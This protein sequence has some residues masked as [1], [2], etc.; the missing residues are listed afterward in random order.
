[1]YTLTNSSDIIS[2][3]INDTLLSTDLVNCNALEVNEYYNNTLCL[4]ELDLV[5][6]NNY[7][8]DTLY[9]IGG[10]S[11]KILVQ[12]TVTDNEETYY[13][14]LA[15]YSRGEQGNSLKLFLFTDIKDS[16]IKLN[17]KSF[18]KVS[19]NKIVERLYRSSIRLERSKGELFTE[20]MKPTGI[21]WIQDNKNDIEFI[22]YLSEKSISV[23]GKGFILFYIDRFCN[24]HFYTIDYL[25]R[26]DVKFTMEEDHNYNISSRKLGFTNI[27]KDNSNFLW[28]KTGSL[29]STVKYFDTTTKRMESK[30]FNFNI[31]RKMGFFRNVR[32]NQINDRTFLKYTTMKRP[33]FTDDYITNNI[34]NKT[35]ES[36]FLGD[37]LNISSN[38]DIVGG[39]Q[40]VLLGDKVLLKKKNTI[41]SSV[42]EDNLSLSGSYL[43]TGIKSVYTR[44]GTNNFFELMRN[45][46]NR[47]NKRSL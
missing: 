34:Q 4:A 28:N 24:L 31:Q 42:N 38:T 37:K 2:I 9:L 7:I 5:D 33:E 14:K 35:E 32:E 1:M 45:S 8:N 10:E 6:F 27:K 3:T 26:K 11:V 29:G 19:P 47:N 13:F 21:S 43:I 18:S 36:S 17:T 15:Y 25:L 20:N 39:T 23:S 12:N 44:E 30:S 41:S 46:V 16:N 40:R 22:K